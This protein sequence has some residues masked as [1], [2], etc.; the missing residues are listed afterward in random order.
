MPGVA[1]QLARQRENLE[2]L[3]EAS[4]RNLGLDIGKCRRTSREVVVIELLTIAIRV[5][6]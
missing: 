2:R 5:S 6:M 4:E 1:R 3:V